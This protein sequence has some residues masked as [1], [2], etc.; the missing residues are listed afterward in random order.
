[1]SK[2]DWKKIT[3]ATCRLEG[4]TIRDPNDDIR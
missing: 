1:M 2:V 4:T 3:K